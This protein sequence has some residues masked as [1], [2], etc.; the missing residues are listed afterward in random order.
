[1]SLELAWFYPLGVSLTL[2]IISYYVIIMIMGL[3][4]M[5]VVWES[6]SMES[7]R[8]SSIPVQVEEHGSQNKIKR[9]TCRPTELCVLVQT[10]ADGSRDG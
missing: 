9:G 5:E 3:S 7:R 4:P 10:W 6:G 8:K 1:M 2:A